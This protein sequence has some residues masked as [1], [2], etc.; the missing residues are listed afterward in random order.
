MSVDHR[1]IL[2]VEDNED[3]VFIFERAYKQ[4]QLSHP[5]QIVRDGQEALDYLQGEGKFA[6]RAKY[7]LPFLVLLDLKLPLTPGL[8]VLQIL[9][10][11]PALADLM[12]VVLTSS[13]ETRDVL[14]AHELGAQAFLVKPPAPKTIATAVSA[15]RARLDAPGSNERTMIDGDIFRVALPTGSR[16]AG[17][18]ESG[19]TPESQELRAGSSELLP[20]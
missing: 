1:T 7:P 5:V 18:E 20:P 8:E 16:S 19:D 15:I 11:Q 12:V 9:R 10:T 13:A 6:D 2:L 14:R 4:T 17:A 3:D